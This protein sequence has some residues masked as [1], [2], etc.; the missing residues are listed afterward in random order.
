M[1]LTD[2]AGNT[3]VSEIQSF[4]TGVVWDA[5]EQLMSQVE[6]MDLSAYTQASVQVLQDA[7]KAAQHLPSDATQQQVDAAAQALQDAIDGLERKTVDN[8]G[9]QQPGGNETIPPKTGENGTPWAGPL[10][11]MGLGLL[12][13]A[14]YKRKQIQSPHR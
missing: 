10:L 11:L 5:L 6:N 3:T 9:D 14:I 2:L 12:A 7:L 4:A 1:T 8:G 13:A